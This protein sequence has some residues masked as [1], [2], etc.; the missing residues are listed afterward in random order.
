MWA[1]GMCPTG[2]SPCVQNRAVRPASMALPRGTQEGAYGHDV[3]P[4]VCCSGWEQEF[5][6]VLAL[7][8]CQRQLCSCWLLFKGQQS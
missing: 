3:F 6:K 8:Q 1:Q 5:C 4:S 7:L 2:A